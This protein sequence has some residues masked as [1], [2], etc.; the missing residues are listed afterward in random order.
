M[1]YTGGRDGQ[2]NVF[3]TPGLEAGKS[4]TIGGQ[5]RAVDCMDGMLLCGTKD[6]TLC[7]MSAD[8]TGSDKKEIMHSHNNGEVWGL[9]QASDN[10][11]MTTGDDNKTMAWDTNKRCMIK[12]HQ[13]TDSKENPRGASS[14]SSLPAAQQ[15]RAVCTFNGSVVVACN[16]GCVR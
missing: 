6:G 3:T 4:Y 11:I 15:G 7:V 12:C 16:D 13:I 2:V 5:V 14:Q 8:G 9:F 1:L 10:I